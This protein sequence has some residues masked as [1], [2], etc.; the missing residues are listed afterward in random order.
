MSNAPR[1]PAVRRNWGVADGTCGVLHV[2]MDAFFVAVE[3]ADNPSLLGRRIIVGGEERSVVVC[4][5]YEAREFGVRAAMPMSHARRLCPDAVIITPRMSRYREVS[6]R[7]MEILGDVTPTIEQ[8]SVDEAYLDVTGVRRHWR[9]AGEIAQAIRSRVADELNVSCSVGVGHSKLIAKLAST[10]AKPDGLLV[11]PQSAEVDFIQRLPVEALPGVGGRT[12]QT[13]RDRGIGTVK[14]LAETDPDV[15]RYWLGVSGTR[16]HFMAWARDPRPV[17]PHR[18][19]LSVGAERTFPTDTR[20][21]AEIDRMLVRL[22]DSVASTLRGR[23]QLASAVALKTR[24]SDLSVSSRSRQ[25]PSPSDDPRVILDAARGL[26]AAAPM[27]GMAVRLVGVRAERLVAQSVVGHQLTLDE[28]LADQS[29]PLATHS[30]I[31]RIRGRFGHDALTAA[32][33]LRDGLPDRGSR[34]S[35]VSDGGIANVL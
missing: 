28:S 1:T 21:A 13:L 12:A 17:E 7:V 27:H 34:D 2:D 16:L 10:N 22:A 23:G 9:D 14:Q 24:R 30:A 5:S 15:L 35:G 18:V 11:I 6:R 3:V 4:A 20:D 29:D 8:V 19:E 31:D 26:F 25:L 32:S 33:G